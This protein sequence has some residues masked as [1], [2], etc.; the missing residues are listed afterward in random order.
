MHF[1]QNEFNINNKIDI[2]YTND[3]NNNSFKNNGLNIFCFNIRSLRNKFDEFTNFIESQQFL[4]HVIVLNEIWIYSNENISFQLENYNSYFCNRDLNRGGGIAIY[5]H[6]SIDSNCLYSSSINNDYDFLLVELINYNIK[7]L[8]VYNQP[9]ANVE[10]FIDLLSNITNKYKN[11]YVAGDTNINLLEN[12]TDSLNYSNMIYSNGYCILNSLNRDFATRKTR[13][14]Y[15]ILDHI[16]TDIVNHKYTLLVADSY[17]SDHCCILLNIHI[18]NFIPKNTAIEKTIIDY[19]SIDRTNLI[20]ISNLNRIENFHELVLFIKKILSDNKKV[21]KG[22]TNTIELEKPYLTTKI[23]EL[24]KQKEKYYKLSLDYPLNEF[25]K[26]QLNNLKKVSFKEIRKSKKQYFAGKIEN[27]KNGNKTLWDLINKNILNKTVS[28]KVNSIKINND[29]ISDNLQISNLFNEYFVNVGSNLVKSRK[30][31]SSIRTIDVSTPQ[32]TPELT[33]DPTSTP[34]IFNIIKSLNSN[35]SVGHDQ[36]SVKFLQRYNSQISPVLSTIINCCISSGSYPNCLKTGLIT[37]I[38]KSGCKQTLSNYRPI[39]VP[40]S[41]SKLFEIVLFNRIQHHCR[42][43]NLLNN[44]QFGFIP[45][46]NTIAATTQLVNELRS[47]LDKN[48]KVS[49]I[50][51][52][53]SKAFDTINHQLL[54]NKL[55]NI[56]CRGKILELLKSY[57]TDRCQIV[58][59]GSTESSHQ[60]LKCGVPQ[61]SNLGPLFFNIFLND[62][63]SL[64][65]NGKMVC[66]AD[67]IAITYSAVDMDSVFNQMQQDLNMINDW[68]ETN[69]LFMNIEKTKFM[70]FHK[71]YK[72]E[73]GIIPKLQIKSTSIEQVTTI[74]YLGLILD[75]GLKWTLHVNKLICKISSTNYALRRLCSLLPDKAKWFFFNSCIMSQVSYLNPIWNAASNQLMSNLRVALNR[76]IKIIRNVPRLHPSEDLYNAKLLPLDAFNKYSTIMLIY[77]IKN[78][79]IKHNFNLKLNTEVH[80]YLTRIRNFFYIETC[81]SNCGQ[82]NI[83]VLGLKLFNNL[84]IQMKEIKKISIFKNQLKTH[85]YET[86]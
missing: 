42:T 53:L 85:L 58:K 59:I 84:P 38:H 51:I 44:N 10:R 75:E 22:N 70:I 8:G 14:H 48:H 20:S 83:L 47:N 68:L 18:N 39:T 36:I 78:N 55:Q 73:T 17:L 5:I 81:N 86:R 23:M 40:P 79:I 77:K 80:N 76:S 3:L 2:H 37:P 52:D 32:S 1:E 45:K 72:A 12:N 16:F 60:L 65:I 19:D 24:L 4:I 57:F 11:L 50:F 82:N 27:S 67:D 9:A 69:S 13:T 46:S 35:S 74:K 71:G 33:M 49:A 64:P 66:Y 6:K 41:L 21:I 7:I 54:L 61:G 25:Y 63:F 30:G 26:N 56:G 62:V 34:E 15:S 31:T 29:V 43:H 28:P